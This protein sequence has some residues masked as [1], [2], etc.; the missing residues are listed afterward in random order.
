MEGTER[1]DALA[2][3]EL[4]F[5]LNPALIVYAIDYSTI[6]DL[7][8]ALANR[9]ASGAPKAQPGGLPRSGKAVDTREGGNGKERKGTR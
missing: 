9:F 5:H 1:E 7:W 8:T 3:R 2:R 6:R 4:G